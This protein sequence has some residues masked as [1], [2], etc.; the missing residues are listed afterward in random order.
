MMGVWDYLGPLGSI[1]LI[2]RKGG[3][4]GKRGS[5]GFI[6][7]ILDCSQLLFD[8]IVTSPLHM[9]EAYVLH[10]L[11]FISVP[12]IISSSP[13][14]IRRRGRPPR[15]TV[16][17]LP[18]LSRRELQVLHLLIPGNVSNESEEAEHA[19][20]SARHDTFRVDGLAGRVAVA[21][22][23]L[24]ARERGFERVWREEVDTCALRVEGFD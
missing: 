3:G 12:V 5:G 23:V 6:F 15:R 4:G 18:P 13:P 16:P 21:A 22:K 10:F 8:S 11:L 20:V 19:A 2:K 9:V 14:S 7:H 1:E 24:A 17:I